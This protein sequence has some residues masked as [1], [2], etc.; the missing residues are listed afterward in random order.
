MNDF[1][2]YLK[3]IGEIG[4]VTEVLNTIV[5]ANGLPGAKPNEIVVFETGELGQILSLLSDSVEIL[6]FSNNSFKSGTRL[7]RTGSSL[8]LPVGE[9]LLGNIIDP[10]GNSLEETKKIKTP[11]TLANL[12]HEPPGI[13]TRKTIKRPFETNVSMVDLMVPLGKGQRELV[14]GDRKTGKTSFLLQ[15][16][17]TQAKLGSICIYAC[18]GKRKI[19]I[20]KAQ[21]FFIE[22]KIMDKV[23]IVA[24]TSTHPTGLIYLTPSSAMAI[25]EYFRDLGKDVLVILDDMLTHAKYYREISLLGKKFPGRNSYPGDIFY[26][27]AGLIERAGNFITKSGGESSITCLAVAETSQG[28][29]SGYIQT[30][31]I[32][33]T[34]GHLFFDTD[35]FYRGQRPS[36]NPFL[37]ISR[38]G[39]QTQSKVKRSIN[40]ELISFLTLYEKVR[41]FAHFGSE[42]N[43]SARITIEMGDNIMNIFKQ[44]AG[45]TIPSNVQALI[46][47][48]LW[49]HLNGENNADILAQKRAKLI[50]LYNTNVKFRDDLDKFVES[51]VSLND[52]MSK[53]KKNTKYVEQILSL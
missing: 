40:R 31:L 14:I 16:I 43:Q 17:Y 50:T 26:V 46:F 2:K 47:T 23:I 22:H 30:N 38:V 20:K 53:L 32:S 29:L 44:A 48:I 37:S 3:E 11:K 28:D 4:F 39:R 52:F 6:T 25:A 36:V 33:M 34:D 21:E 24:S 12:N 1:D 41:N 9:E 19:D 5:F 49:G 15:T 42:L 13:T 35:M 27:H 51:S 8:K 10:L 18:I 7:V 45:E